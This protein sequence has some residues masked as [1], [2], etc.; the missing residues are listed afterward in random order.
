MSGAERLAHLRTMVEMYRDATGPFLF[1]EVVTAIAGVPVQPLNLADG[2]DA[3]LAGLLARA[4]A[5]AFGRLRESPIR[6]VTSQRYGFSAKDAVHA[7]L[8]DCGLE[9]QRPRTQRGD[10]PSTGYPDFQIVDPHSRLTYAMVKTC[11]SDK[12]GDT[13]RTL[14]LSPGRSDMDVK[15]TRP[16]RHVLISFRHEEIRLDGRPAIRPVRWSV[17]DLYDLPV[18]LKYEFNSNNRDLFVHRTDLILREG[19]SPSEGSRS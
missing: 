10:R 2:R 1:H 19:P 8:L 4:T 11:A 16:A 6:D 7:A 14:Y 13:S 17:H 5:T 18:D 12:S 9:P 15:I 3:E